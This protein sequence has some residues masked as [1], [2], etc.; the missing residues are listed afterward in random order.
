[1]TMIFRPQHF[2]PVFRAFSTSAVKQGL[3]SNIG[4][5][6]IKYPTNVTLTPS[7]TALS[8][9]GPLGTTSVPLHPFVHLQFSEPQTLSVSVED[10]KEKNEKSHQVAFCRRRQKTPTH[11][12]F[13]RILTARRRSSNQDRPRYSCRARRHRRVTNNNRLRSLNAALSRARVF[14]WVRLPFCRSS[15]C[16]WLLLRVR[17]AVAIPYSAARIDDLRRSSV[18]HRSSSTRNLAGGEAVHRPV[19]FAFLEP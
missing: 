3:V 1:M 10:A 13:R 19:N 12:R 11:L 8:V 15:P 2:Q 7:P 4:K 18:L 9:Q 6:A 17:E 14:L 16:L 5:Q